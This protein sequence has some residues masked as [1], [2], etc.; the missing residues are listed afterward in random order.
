MEEMVGGSALLVA[1]LLARNWREIPSGLFLALIGLLA[2]SRATKQ[3][4]DR[5]TGPDELLL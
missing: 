4:P 2:V 3:W 5:E 1:G